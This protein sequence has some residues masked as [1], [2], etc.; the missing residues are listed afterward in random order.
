MKTNLYF[1]GLESI[2]RFAEENEIY[3]PH[4]IRAL[5][6]GETARAS[7]LNV[8]EFSEIVPCYEV[9]LLDDSDSVYYVEAKYIVLRIIPTGEVFRIREVSRGKFRLYLFERPNIH[10]RDRYFRFDMQEPNLIGKATE[11]K[12]SAWIDFLHLERTALVNYV[13]ANMCRN[14]TFAERVRAKYPDAKFVTA[15]DGWTGEICFD[16]ERFRVKY[17]AHENGEFSRQLD[18]RHLALPSNEEIL[19]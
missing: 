13:N 16:W 4:Y 14:V 1:F 15:P 7:V 12:I 19:G 2:K 5:D 9:R 17:T 18:I 3:N 8:P 10:W 6:L 11:K